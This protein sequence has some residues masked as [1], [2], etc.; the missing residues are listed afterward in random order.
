MAAAR[1][2]NARMKRPVIFVVESGGLCGGVRQIF[3]QAKRLSEREWPVKIFTLDRQPAWFAMPDSVEWRQF[4]D[5]D[6][7]KAVLVA[8]TGWKVATW[9]KTAYVVTECLRGDEGCYLVADIETEYYTRPIEKEKVLDSYGLP[10]R[11]YTESKWVEENLPDTTWIGIGIDHGLLYPQNT[12]RDYTTIMSIA[13]KQRLKGYRQLGELSR[14]LLHVMPEASLIT[15]GLQRTELGGVW[16]RHYSGLS[17][18][19]MARLYNQV[20]CVVSTS[21]HEGFGLPHIEAMACGTPLVTTDADAN[22]EF[23]EHGTNCLMFDWTD[24]LGMANGI[25]EIYTN[26]GLRKSL[27]ANG[28][29]TAARYTWEPVIDRLENFLD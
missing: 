24:M 22:K 21:L 13:R 23:C 16:K 11:R 2:D 3:E 9:W 10:L 26:K 20:G 17:D 15:V 7:L 6:H 8:E 18:W 5:Y 19:E 14:R 29:E 1:E 25:R 27:V 12:E 28:L 4:P